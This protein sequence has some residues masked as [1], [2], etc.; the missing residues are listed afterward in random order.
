MCR[1]LYH[2][3]IS[4]GHAPSCD[5]ALSIG[6]D[7]KRHVWI[8]LHCDCGRDLALSEYQRW[9]NSETG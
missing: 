3:L 8:P 4:A 1:A 9:A 6:Y 5:A 2:A 7:E